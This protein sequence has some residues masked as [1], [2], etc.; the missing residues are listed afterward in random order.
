MFVAI[1]EKGNRVYS[2]EY[3]SGT[4]CFCPECRKPLRYKHGDVY[5]PYFAHHQKSECS[6]GTDK[7]HLSEWHIRMQEYFPKEQRE[8][9]FRDEDTGEVHIADIY[10]KEMETVIEFQHSPIKTEEFL[11]RTQFHT[12]HNRRIVWVFDES[13]KTLQ[14]GDLGRFRFDPDLPGEWPYIGRMFRWMRFPRKCLLSIPGLFFSNYSI[15]VYTGTEGDILHHLI[16]QKNGYKYVYFSLHDIEMSESVDIE[17]FFKPEG[18]WMNQS[19]L[20]E[21]LEKEYAAMLARRTRSLPRRNTV[22]FKFSKRPRRGW[23]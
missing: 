6:W 18:F 2:D 11:A 5:R 13:K 20:K 1:D 12:M 8:V 9:R 23:L 14:D 7:D 15:C 22:N 3:I 16:D 19:P 17:E 4:K 21:Q 10:V